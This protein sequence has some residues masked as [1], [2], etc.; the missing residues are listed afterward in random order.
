MDGYYLDMDENFLI[1][2]EHCLHETVNFLTVNVYG[3]CLGVTVYSLT[4]NGCCLNVA[5]N[6]LEEAGNCLGVDENYLYVDVN[7]LV[8]SLPSS[9]VVSDLLNN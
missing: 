1:L 2:G 7:H 9:N 6:C 5:G 4:V 8:V 3:H